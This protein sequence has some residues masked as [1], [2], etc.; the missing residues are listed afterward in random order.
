MKH[1]QIT[2]DLQERASLYAAGAMPPP[3]RLEYVRHMEDDDCTVCRN[4]ATELET[5][6]TLLAYSVP[7]RTPSSSLKVRLVEQARN[8]RPVAEKRPSSR[9]W[10]VDFALASI[11]AAALVMMTVTI[12][13][14]QELREL[15]S[16]LTSRIAQLEVQLQQQQNQ[17]ATL[18]SP[19]VRVVDMAGQGANVGAGARIFW[20]QQQ[21]RWLL[22]VRD[23]PP[24]AANQTY[25]LWFVPRTGNPVS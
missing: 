15:T 6:A 19:Q 4:E 20:D 2:D 16:S 23:L 18:T 7:V 11:A 25:Q 10:L 9:W 3:E 1:Q 17:F 24:V 14:N 13:S 12:N 21:R 22:Y 8:A 5:V